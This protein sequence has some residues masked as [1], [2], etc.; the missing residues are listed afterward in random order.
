MPNKNRFGKQNLFK[1]MA[2]VTI[3][4]KVLQEFKSLDYSEKYIMDYAPCARPAQLTL[5][6]HFD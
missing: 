1:S 3:V 2:T 6:I 5:N 4:K